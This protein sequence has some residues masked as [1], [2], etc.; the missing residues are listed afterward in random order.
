MKTYAIRGARTKLTGHYRVPGT[1]DLYCNKPAG[2]PNDIAQQVKGFKLCT[3]CVKAE[4]RDRA[5]A[6][7]T[8]E[9]WLDRPPASPLAAAALA[10]GGLVEAVDN[11]RAAERAEAATLDNAVTTVACPQCHAAAGTRCTTRTGKPA[12]EPH[13][14]R[15]GALE[16]AAG[17]T[18]HPATERREAEARGK[19]V[20]ALDRKAEETLLAAYVARINARTEREQAQAAR[21]RSHRAAERV[22]TNPDPTDPEWRAALAELRAA[23]DHEREVSPIAREAIDAVETEAEPAGTWRAEWISARTTSPAPTL[24]DVEPDAEQGALFA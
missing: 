8:A 6:T 13:G 2:A 18:Q 21:E 11:Q 5:A 7:A 14:R 12:R 24:F 1:R 16:D 19:L 22:R 3:Q 23:L 20:V 15:F 10:F 9:A 4:A 17:I